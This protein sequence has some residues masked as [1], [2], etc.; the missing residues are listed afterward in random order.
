MCAICEAEAKNIA[1]NNAAASSA[2]VKGHGRKAHG[3]DAGHKRQVSEDSRE[4]DIDAA[5]DHLY[6]Q[7]LNRL[8][9][10]PHPR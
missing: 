8:R 3:R 5:W 2:R 10:L 1:D 4:R 7:A 6:Q 9:R